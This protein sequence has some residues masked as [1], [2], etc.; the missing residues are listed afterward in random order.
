MSAV[1]LGQLRDHGFGISIDD[2]G[3]GY[4]SFAHLQRFPATE[5][6]IDQEFVP[7]SATARVRRG[8]CIR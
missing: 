1:V 6:K 4:S 8:W 3:I 5:L 2:F 7:T